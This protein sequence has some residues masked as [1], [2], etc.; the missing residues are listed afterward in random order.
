MTN[1]SVKIRDQNDEATSVTHVE[2]L[3]RH[4]L[5]DHLCNNIDDGDS[6]N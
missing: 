6:A 1:G 2:D 5:E 3:E 4:F